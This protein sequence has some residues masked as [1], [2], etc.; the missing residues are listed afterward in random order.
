MPGRERDLSGDRDHGEFGA[1]LQDPRKE[2][3]PVGVQ[4]LGQDDGGRE[5]RRKAGDQR[6]ERLD[7]P[8]PDG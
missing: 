8:G 2:A 5:V 7:P 3:G 1:T 6:A 4:V